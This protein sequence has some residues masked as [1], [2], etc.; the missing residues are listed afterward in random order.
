[1]YDRENKEYRRSSYTRN[2]NKDS[3]IN[4]GF[5][6]ILFLQ[7]FLCVV[8]VLASISIKYVG[9]NLYTDFKTT[10]NEIMDESLTITKINGWIGQAEGWIDQIVSVFGKSPIGENI[11][12]SIGNTNKKNNVEGM[13]GEMQV[14]SIYDSIE[15][16]NMGKVV[17]PGDFVLPVSAVNVT[18][19]YGYREHP[20]TG[21]L[22]FHTGID[23]AAEEGT[24]IVAIKP[25]IVNEVGK[26]DTYGNYVSILHDSGLETFYAHC[27][28][29]VVKENKRVGMGDVIARVGNTGVSTGY[30]VHIETRLNGVKVDPNCI[31]K[32]DN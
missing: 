26:S 13:G 30:H 23:F 6:T 17:I 32:L 15:G 16:V 24:D 5:V 2:S 19:L 3:R 25:G 18:S 28:K 8:I 7:I 21:E 14:S 10:Y 1:M 11:S 31:F 12:I 9:D 29:I 22:D 4:G 20:I 27:E